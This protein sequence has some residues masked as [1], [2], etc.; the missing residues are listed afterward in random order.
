MPK[1]RTDP[2]FPV[3]SDGL[4][5]RPCVGIMVLNEAGKVWVGKRDD[6]KGASEYEFAWQMPQGGIDTSEDPKV[7]ALRELYEETSIHSVSVVGETADW[8][9]YDYPAEVIAVSRRKKYRGQAQKWYAVR[10]TGPVD[11]INVLSP[12]DGHKPEFCEWKWV[13]AQTLP[14]L[15]VPFKRGVYEVVVSAFSHLTA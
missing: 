9:T 14:G 1:E 11:E 4:P 7:A 5:Y 13:D 6:G 10:F 8:L 15:I 2:G 3:V 12:P